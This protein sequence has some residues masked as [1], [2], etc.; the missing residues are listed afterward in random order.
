MKRARRLI[1]CPACSQPHAPT[2]A[3]CYA[4]AAALPPRLR[5]LTQNAWW[6]WAGKH[7]A[8]THYSSPSKHAAWLKA[9]ALAKHALKSLPESPVHTC[10]AGPAFTQSG[11]RTETGIQVDQP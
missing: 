8:S 2:W 1:P 6:H 10:P 11:L 5:K 9:L 4:C 7:D 3:L